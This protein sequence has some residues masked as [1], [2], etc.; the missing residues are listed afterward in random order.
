MDSIEVKSV[1]RQVDVSVH[2][3][4]LMQHMPA[5]DN[6]KVQSFIDHVE[7]HGL[8]GLPG[9]LKCSTEVPT[10]DPCWLS[11]VTFARTWDLKH[12]HVG[13]PYWDYSKPQGDYT[14][15]WVLHLRVP[16]QDSET[17]IIVDWDSPPPFQLP[18]EQYFVTFDDTNPRPFR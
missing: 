1:G 10:D 12:Y 6:F 9:R 11:K 8:I 2:F 17:I 18:K 16:S 15:E 7:Q 5:N 13:V 3:A 4:R 14:S